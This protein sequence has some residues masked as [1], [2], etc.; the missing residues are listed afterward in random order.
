MFDADIQVCNVSSDRLPHLNFLLV[1]K[2]NILP[3]ES[4]DYL[5]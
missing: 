1:K 5:I 2:G 3:K 4:G